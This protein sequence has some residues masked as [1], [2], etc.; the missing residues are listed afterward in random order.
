MQQL[1]AQSKHYRVVHEYETVFLIGAT[2]HAITIGDFYGDPQAALIDRHERWCIVV[3]EGL[4]VYYLH[5]PF[6]PYFR[7]PPSL[8]PA[9]IASEQW[10]TRFRDAEK[11]WWIDTVCQ[12]GDNLVEFAVDSASEHSGVYNLS[13]PDLAVN[14]VKPREQP[15]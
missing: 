1:L 9:L 2:E 15:F 12:I 8:P 13:I 11:N 7:P 4:I 5:P 10:A 14:Q 3:G 6:S